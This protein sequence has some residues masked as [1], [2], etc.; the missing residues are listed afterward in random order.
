MFITYLMQGNPIVIYPA[1]VKVLFSCL[2][3]VTARPHCLSLKARGMSG[4]AGA[5]ALIGCQ[6]FC[7]V[8]FIG[9]S[10][11]GV[12][13]EASDGIHFVGQQVQTGHG[14]AREASYRYPIPSLT[15]G[16]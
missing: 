13:V 1:P 8:L 7:L 12:K 3:P 16:F 11:N 15:I 9:L 2:R 5:R 14:V 4:T 10:D 6:C